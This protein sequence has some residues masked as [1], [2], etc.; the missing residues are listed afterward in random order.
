MPD[1]WE[2]KLF[3]YVPPE[4]ELKVVTLV[5]VAVVAVF[6][7]PLEPWPGPVKLR[8]GRVI[9]RQHWEQSGLRLANQGS[10]LLIGGSLGGH[11]LVGDFNLPDKKIEF[12]SL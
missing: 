12:A 8:A 1:N 10:R 5:P 4:C 6:A 3:E 7:A 2:R 11:R 9:C